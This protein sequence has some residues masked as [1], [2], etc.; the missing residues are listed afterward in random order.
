[1]ALRNIST[2][3][4]P[5]L[6]KEAENIKDLTDPEI[7]TL[8]EDMWECMYHY[9][10]I[11]LAAP[12]V[13]VSKK[14][15][16]IDFEGEKY[17]LINPVITERKGSRKEDEGCLSFPGIYVNVESPESIKVEYENENGEFIKRDVDGF[18]ACVFS[19]EIDHLYGRT[20]IDRVSPIKR[21]FIKKKME[22]YNRY[23]EEI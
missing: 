16:V 1:M 6:R 20:L 4:D 15:A 9:D 7:K 11:G 17:T 18:L 3:P 10:G 2:Y 19:H 23:K 22:K 5:V 14:I 21:Q 13:G 8:I 12:Q